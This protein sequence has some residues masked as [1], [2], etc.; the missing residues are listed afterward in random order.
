MED[1]PFK[2]NDFKCGVCGKI[3]NN[4]KEYLVCPFCEEEKKNA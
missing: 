1:L 4:P 3:V 2:P